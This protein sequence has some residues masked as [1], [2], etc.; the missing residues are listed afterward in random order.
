V[1]LVWNAWV[2]AADKVRLRLC[3]PTNTATLDPV[4]QYWRVDVWQH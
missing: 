4:S 1:A 2:P 3:N